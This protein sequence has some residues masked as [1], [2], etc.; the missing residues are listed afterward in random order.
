MKLRPL[1]FES[2]PRYTFW[3]Q[4][5]RPWQR[6][7]AVAALLLLLAYLGWCAGQGLHAIRDSQAVKE[8]TAEL[9]VTSEEKPAV[10]KYPKTASTKPASDS[11]GKTHATSLSDDTRRNLNTVIRHLNT[12]WQDLFDQLERLTPTDIA[13]LSIE[14]DARRGSIKL[15]AEAKTLEALLTYA[16]SLEQQGV[17]GRL[18]Y[19]K[20]ETNDQDSNKPTRLSFELGLRAPLRLKPL[21]NNALSASAPSSQAIASAREAK[22]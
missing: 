1:H 10:N 16:A 2:T 11:L 14:H 17:F 19:S 15:Q 18:T 4:G 21:A 20:Y 9:G 13:L 22:P 7:L 5:S 12:P 6:L 8:R 3:G